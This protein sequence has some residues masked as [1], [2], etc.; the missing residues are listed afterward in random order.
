METFLVRT[1]SF[2]FVHF[3]LK[4]AY[5]LANFLYSYRKGRFQK[6]VWLKKKY[7]DPK[8]NLVINLF[9]KDLIDHKILFTGKYEKDTNWVLE[10]HVHQGQTVL[11]A[12][13]NS[14]TETLLI[15]RLV[16]DSGFVHAFEPFEPVTSKLIDNLRLNAGR[17]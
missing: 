12:G 9:S 5:R 1:F 13:A 14:G 3:R 7:L 4:G 6:G 2:I 10:N 16:G 17:K 8:Y 15:S 11:E